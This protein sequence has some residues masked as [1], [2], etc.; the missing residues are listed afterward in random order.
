MSKYN[1]NL[2]VSSSP[3]LVTALDTQKTMLMVM[4][5]LCPSLCVS[6]YVF[7]PRVILLTA[8]SMVACMFFEWAWNAMLKRRQ[9]VSDLSAALTGMLIAFNVPSGLPIWTLLVGD[10]AAI[11]VV[12][13]LFGG[14]GKNLVNPAITARI[15]M[16]IS[17][18]TEMTT[19]TVPRMAA[20]ATS[21]ATP[22]GVLA[23]G[24][25][26]DLPSNVHMF[27][28]FIGGSFGEVSAVALIVGGIF[29]VWKKIISPIIPCCFIGTVFVFALIYY[30]ATGQGDPLQMAVFH[31][32]A[33][34]VMLG[35]IFMATDYVTSPLLPMGK[36]VFGIGC[37]LMTMVIRI[38]GQYPEGVSFSILLMNCLTPLINDFFQKRMYGGKKK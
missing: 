32:L 22:L 5:A 23:E 2:I 15:I 9:T 25:I 3:H 29:L 18:A 28:G 13:Q 16:F 36:V 34:G 14:I 20:D 24:S 1:D 38:W 8:V 11:I 10:F 35:A 30:A 12:K 21:T 26:S 6:I 17:F 7:G 19:W 31:I 4:I 37:G 33:G 27:L